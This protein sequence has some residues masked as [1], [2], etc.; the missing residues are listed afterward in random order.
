[1]PAGPD[2]TARAAETRAALVTA[3][4]QLFVT[5]GYFATGTEEIVSRAGVTRGAL[6]HHFADKR[7]LFRE[8]FEAVEHE[9]LEHLVAGVEPST[10]VWDELRSGLHGYLRA[11]ASNLEFQRIIL[12]DGPAVL[13]W[14]DWRELLQRHVLGLVEAAIE[15]AIDQ[16]AI[17]GQ[18][19]TP[20]AAILLGAVNE[21]ALLVANSQ[22]SA[23]ARQ[24]ASETLDRLLAGLRQ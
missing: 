5:D 13:G 2:Q 19:V 16:Q 4:R 10:H 15:H 1:M 8:V 9:A 24:E 20:L 17:A 18:P 22:N 14:P 11:A 7:S 21:A 12:V 3:A 23:T 6:Y